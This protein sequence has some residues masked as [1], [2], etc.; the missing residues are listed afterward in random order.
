MSCYEIEALRLGLMNVLGT[1]DDHAR[2][3]AEQE[4]EGHMTGPIEAL[5]GA[6]TLAAIERHLDA[7]LVD[8][9][10]E[11][12]ATPEDDPEYDYLRGRLVAVRDAER[13]VSRITMQ[14]EDVLAG[15]GEAH[16]VLHEA[17]PVDE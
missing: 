10:E 9:E 4:L 7:A 13:A 6:K 3:H 16:D 8:L 2:Q 1:E 12:A 15:L 14:G 11:I 5:A 17:F